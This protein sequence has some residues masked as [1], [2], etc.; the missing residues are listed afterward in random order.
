MPNLTATSSL[1]DVAEILHAAAVL[2]P[3]AWNGQSHKGTTMEPN[4]EAKL[5]EDIA[6]LFQVLHERSLPYVLVGGIAMLAYVEG[7]NTQDLDLVLS[8]ASLKKLPEIVLS[9]HNAEFARGKFGTLRVDVLLADNP[10]FRLVQEKHTA[11]RR[12]FGIDIRCATVE[13]LIL[14]K[15]YAL[16]SL[17]RQGDGQRIGLYENDVFMLCE[18]H[19]P[20]MAPLLNALEPYV[21]IGPMSELRSIVADIRRR[22]ERV[23]RARREGKPNSGA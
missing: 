9:D 12:L 23:D 18:R 11:T 4:I 2:G 8:L 17:Y 7:R 1:A 14:L 19:R 3:A 10:L 15:L 20:D 21:E 13:G 5:R 6:A 16:P 22:I